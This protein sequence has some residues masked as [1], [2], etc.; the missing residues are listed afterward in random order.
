MPG[1]QANTFLCLVPIIHANYVIQMNYPK[2]PTRDTPESPPWSGQPPGEDA[3]SEHRMDSS[4]QEQSEAGGGEGPAARW[5][6]SCD[7]LCSCRHFY[8]RQEP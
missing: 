4:S 7:G 8:K 2:P 5:V 3:S 1:A 6:W